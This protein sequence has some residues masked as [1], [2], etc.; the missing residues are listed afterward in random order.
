MIAPD[1]RPIPTNARHVAIACH[2]W[3]DDDFGGSFR[4]ASE[5]AEFLAD[6]GYAVTFVCCAPLGKSFLPSR[7]T[8][9][10]VAIRRYPSPRAWLPRL[11]RLRYHVRQTGRCIREAGSERP[12]DVLAGPPPLQFLG[13]ARQLRPAV[14]KTF[15]VHSPL[16]DELLANVGGRAGWRQRFSARLGNWV[17]GRCIAWADRVHTASRYT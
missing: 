8:I 11:A 7:E 9:R 13:A 12:I 14:F 4:L 5:F 15:F 6:H 1:M 2:A 10:N 17:D 16:D 3:Y